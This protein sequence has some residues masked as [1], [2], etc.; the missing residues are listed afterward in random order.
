MDCTT[1]LVY[2][3]STESSVCTAEATGILEVQILPT[4]G[5]TIICNGKEYALDKFSDTAP[6]F[7]VEV[8]KGQKISLVFKNTSSKM[9][10]KFKQVWY[11]SRVRK[12]EGGKASLALETTPT[13]KKGKRK[14]FMHKIAKTISPK[15]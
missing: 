6:Y 4:G 10:K 13:T 3:N 15:R 8:V 7:E 1:V 5:D 11:L 2:A 12:S 9:W 14:G